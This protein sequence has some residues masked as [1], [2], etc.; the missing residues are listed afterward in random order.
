MKKSLKY[1]L[2]TLAIV[3][4]AYLSFR[5][6]YEGISRPQSC[7]A[8]HEVKPYYVSWQNSPHKGVEC[9]ECHE[10][11]G[12]FGKINGA[13]RGIH[14]LG[15]QITGEYSFLKPAI[16]YDNNCMTCHRGKNKDY[17]K[18]PQMKTAPTDHKKI[19]EEDVSCKNCHKETGHKV[20]LSL[21]QW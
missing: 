8:C 20:S 12:P 1:S 13:I 19:V 17:P 3:A 21:D 7:V 15:I 5:G 2:F 18:A 6:A 9:M 14:D 4:V 16:T 11:R 10:P